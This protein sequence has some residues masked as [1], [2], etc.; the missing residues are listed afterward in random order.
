MTEKP[1]ILFADAPQPT[2]NIFGLPIT[3]SS[4]AS[5]TLAAVYMMFQMLQGLFVSGGQQVQSHQVVVPG[6]YGDEEP[7]P[8]DTVDLSTFRTLGPLGKAEWLRQHGISIN[9]GEPEPDPTT[10]TVHDLLR[11]AGIPTKPGP[12]GAYAPGTVVDGDEE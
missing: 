2:A 11:E 1:R 8:S 9:A 6:G 3:V 7:E 4:G 12:G 5:D 10:A